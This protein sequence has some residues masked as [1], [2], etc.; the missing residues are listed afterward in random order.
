MADGYYKWKAEIIKGALPGLRQSL[1]TES[2]LKMKKNAFYLSLKALFVLEIFRILFWFF[3]HVG[4]RL[5][6]IAEGKFSKF[7]TSQTG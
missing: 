5:D 7:M 1:V 6:M 4:K 3:G 2:P